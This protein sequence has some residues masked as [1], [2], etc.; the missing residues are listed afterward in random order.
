MHWCERGYCSPVRNP[1]E[2][3]LYWQKKSNQD[4]T[5]DSQWPI[6]HWCEQDYCSPVRNL[7]Y[8]QLLFHK[9]SDQYSIDNNQWS[10]AHWCKRGYCSLIKNPTGLRLLSHNRRVTEIAMEENAR[11]HIS[12]NLCYLFH[13]KLNSFICINMGNVWM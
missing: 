1:T 7:A 2:L 6:M 10:I 11:Q 5:N 12:F 9:S 13:S 8:L 3:R 4:S